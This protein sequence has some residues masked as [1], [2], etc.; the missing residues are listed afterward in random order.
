V[1]ARALPCRANRAGFPAYAAKVA[2][3]IRFITVV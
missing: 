3:E 2:I 1:F